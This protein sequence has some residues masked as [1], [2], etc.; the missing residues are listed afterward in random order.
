MFYTRK[1]EIVIIFE[2][3][4]ILQS[5]QHTKHTHETAF[6]SFIDIHLVSLIF[7][8]LFQPQIVEINPSHQSNKG[9]SIRHKYYFQILIPYNKQNDNRHEGMQII[10]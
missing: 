5:I 3:K 7:S 8:N 4:L 10:K 1:L 6:A 2:L 9:G